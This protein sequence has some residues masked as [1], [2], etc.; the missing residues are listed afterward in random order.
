MEVPNNILCALDNGKCVILIMLDLSAACD[1]MDDTILLSRLSS[2]FA[3]REEALSWLESYLTDIIQGI[4]INS[5]KST[6][7]EL[8]CGKVS[9]S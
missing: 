4:I 9:S 5:V 3:M 7:S 6:E 8:V 2:R 1:T